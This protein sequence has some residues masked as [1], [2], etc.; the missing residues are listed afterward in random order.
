MV[1]KLLEAEHF[2]HDAQGVGFTITPRGL[3]AAEE[4]SRAS[5]DGA[6]GFVAMSFN[7]SMN[8]VWTNGFD[9]GI[10]SAG[11]RPFRIDAKDYVGGIA[12]EIMS[13]IRR[14][15]FVVADYTNQVNGVYFEAGF[16]LGIGLTVI[17]TCRED[18]INDL[19]F[20]IRH[21]NTLLWRT[22]E[23]LSIKLQHR[24]RG[25]LSAGPDDPREPE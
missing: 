24:I 4:M 20:D 19:H 18:Q 23:D 2:I 25:V 7:P 16:A 6:Q 12:D 1:L 3:L 13:E 17:P 9:P 15:R 8:D 22:P 10:R 21:L 5:G 11:F 14:S